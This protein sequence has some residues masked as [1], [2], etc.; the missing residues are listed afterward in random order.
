MTKVVNVG[1]PK[2][3]VGKTTAVVLLSYWLGRQGRKVMV[4]DANENQGVLA[5]RGY[6]LQRGGDIP[7]TVVPSSRFSGEVGGWDY[8]VIDSPPRWNEATIY[9]TTISNLMIIPAHVRGLDLV[10]LRAMMDTPAFQSVPKLLLLNFVTGSCRRSACYEQFVQAG[11]ELGCSV[12]QWGYRECYGAVGSGVLPWDNKAQI[13]TDYR[14]QFF[15]EFRLF[16]S[17]LTGIGL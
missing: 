5:W 12:V 16:L 7:F 15:T 17:A 2:G 10:C 1:I 13:K 14:G 4:L 3:G 11:Q 9:A 6:R 8:V